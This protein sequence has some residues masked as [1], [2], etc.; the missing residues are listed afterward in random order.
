MEQ[1]N[2]QAEMYMENISYSSIAV[3]ETGENLRLRGYRE[4]TGHEGRIQTEFDIRANLFVGMVKA[5]ERF[6]V[7]ETEP[8]LVDTLHDL[9]YGEVVGIMQ[10]CGWFPGLPEFP[11]ARLTPI[12]ELTHMPEL[13]DAFERLV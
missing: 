5:V 2:T 10:T 7:C 1:K 6:I 13:P 3:T 11:D 9:P 12:M 4:I 8:R